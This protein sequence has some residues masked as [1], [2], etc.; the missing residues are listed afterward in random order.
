MCQRLCAIWYIASA[1]AKA[2]FFGATTLATTSYLVKARTQRH[3]PSQAVEAV[4]TLSG[5]K[6]SL[7]KMRLCSFSITATASMTIRTPIGGLF[8]VFTTAISAVVKV[9]NAAKAALR[10]GR[11]SPSFASHSS[12]MAI[13]TAACSLAAAS[14]CLT[15]SRC[16]AADLLS[17]RFGTSPEFKRVASTISSMQGSNSFENNLHFKMNYNYEYYFQQWLVAFNAVTL[18]LNAKERFC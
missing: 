18:Y 17:S 15:N 8:I 4:F 16:S 13:A 1:L 5:S 12:L 3:R 6:F 2:I 9:F 10:M 11:A 7:F 14:S